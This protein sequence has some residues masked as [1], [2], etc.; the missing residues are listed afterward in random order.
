ML[1]RLLWVAVALC[2]LGALPNAPSS[3]APPPRESG[4]ALAGAATTADAVRPAAP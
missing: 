3:V 1:A 2:V 4:S